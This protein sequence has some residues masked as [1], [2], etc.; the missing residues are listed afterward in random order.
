[1]AK[2]VPEI[3]L[4]DIRTINDELV[5]EF[6]NFFYRNNLMPL[7]TNEHKVSQIVVGDIEIRGVTNTDG[8]YREDLEQLSKNIG[9]AADNK[10]YE[11][12]IT[13]IIDRP[14]NFISFMQ[15]VRKLNDYIAQG[16][17]VEHAHNAWN[18]VYYNENL[19]L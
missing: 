15:N 12:A 2:I 1:M 19:N 10:R 13:S 8:A 5:K 11:E 6:K 17:Y 3:I 9:I 7:F 14:R 4:F 16:I 18:I